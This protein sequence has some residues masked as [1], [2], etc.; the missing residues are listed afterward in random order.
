[1]K[2]CQ[3]KSFLFHISPWNISTPVLLIHQLLKTSHKKLHLLLSWPQP[4]L[5]VQ[6]QHHQKNICHQ[7]VPPAYHKDPSSWQSN[8]AVP[9][10][11]SELSSWNAVIAL[12]LPLSWKSSSLLLRSPN[13]FL[14]IKSLHIHWT[15]RWWNWW[16]QQAC[17][18]GQAVP[19]TSQHNLACWWHNF[20]L[21]G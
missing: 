8:Q 18:N 14:W 17:Q 21:F 11:I 4:H 7:G 2:S 5:M 9:S 13:R 15:D 3:N 20:K 6:L 16:F 19:K 10:C 12:R 1:V